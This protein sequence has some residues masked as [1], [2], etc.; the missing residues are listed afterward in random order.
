[1]VLVGDQHAD[2]RVRGQ[3]VPQLKRAGRA[4]HR[5]R[6]AG[7]AHALQ[8]GVDRPL[9]RRNG[10]GLGLHARG[11][12]PGVAAPDI[13]NFL[14]VLDAA[15]LLGQA[16]QQVMVLRA[17]KGGVLIRP[18]RL[19]QR[20]GENGQMG[21]V[22][23]AAQIV[24]RK[25]RLEMVAAQ[26][27][28]IRRQDDL[29]GIDK[30]RA[31]IL[32][33]LHRFIQRVGVEQVVV[34]KQRDA[35]PFRQA[36]PG[37]GVGGDALVFDLFIQDARIPGSPF[38][39][40]RA[41]GRVRRVRGVDKHELPVRIGLAAH[42]AQHLPEKRQRRVVYRHHDTD[43]RRAGQRGRALGFELAA[44]RDIG[45]VPPGIV[46]ERQPDAEGHVPPELLRA[47][48]A[49]SGG[50]TAGKVG[51]MGRVEQAAG[52]GADAVG[53]GDVRRAV[54]R[55]VL[56]GGL[57]HRCHLVR[58]GAFRIWRDGRIPHF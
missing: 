42:A 28:E 15:R 58:A 2:K 40:K 37:R 4:G 38:L 56:G 32:E 10:V 54:L 57:R 30:V 26:F 36:E 31:G 3:F 29:V 52:H 55:L 13:E 14:D 43:A 7:Q 11:G 46:V 5:P 8:V 9:P 6:T 24:G 48:L 1:M 20:A 27:F 25:I 33:G 41:G 44:Q 34:V 39:R 18:G 50:R 49:Q 12:R 51:Q 16:Q 35:V 23:V 19:E 22:V 53:R 21:D 45:A 17:V 47:A